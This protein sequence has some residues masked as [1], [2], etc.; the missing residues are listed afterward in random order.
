MEKYSTC[1]YLLI[2][3]LIMI[4]YFNL[5]LFN[6]SVKIKTSSK[7]NEQFNQKWI[8]VTSINEPTKQIVKLSKETQFKLLVVSDLKTNQSWY[9]SNSIFLSIADQKKLNFKSI[10]STPF[11][12]YTRKN[13]GYLFA[14]KN[15]AQFIY[16]TDDDNEPSKALIDYF[17]FEETQIQLEYDFNSPYVLNPYAH[18][19]QPTIW[20]RGF[21]LIEINKNNY[22][23]YICIQ[24]STSIVQQSVV[25]GDPDVDAIFRLTKS[26]DSQRIDIK[27]DLNSPSVRIPLYKFTPYNSQNTFFLYKAFWSLYLPHSVSF[28]LTDIWRSYWA[29]RLMWLLNSTLSFHGPNAYQLRNSHSYMDDYKQEKDMYLQAQDLI[30]FLYEWKC[31][32]KRFY[33]CVLDLSKQMALKKFWALEEFNSIQDWLD[34]LT[35]IG[36]SEPAIT[37]YDYE[38]GLKT[39]NQNYQKKFSFKVTYTP[40][41]EGLIDLKNYYGD[42]TKMNLIERSENVKYFNNFCNRKTHGFSY[43][44]NRNNLFISEGIV[45]LVVFEKELFPLINDS[46]QFLKNYYQPYFKN[47]VFCGKNIRSFNDRNR[48][49]W[50]KFDSL[51]LIDYEWPNLN[52][53][54][55]GCMKKVIDMRYINI[56]GILLTSNN[57][58]LKYWNLDTIRNKAISDTVWY[59]RSNC[60]N[61]T[62]LADMLKKLKSLNKLTIHLPYSNSNNNISEEICLPAYNLFYLPVNKFKNFN[63]LCNLFS[64]ANLFSK[65]AVPIVLSNLDNMN[66]SFYYLDLNREDYLDFKD[67]ILHQFDLSHYKKEEDRFF[68]CDN[69][70]QKIFDFYV[71]SA[72]YLEQPIHLISNAL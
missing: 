37:N 11:N 27:F 5:I 30:R 64:F 16:D 68:L 56:K 28:R 50:K 61:S 51:T 9:Q 17:D 32:F 36:Y 58:L 63:I 10:R 34:D 2:F 48:T 29:Q 47:I 8:V 54:H 72:L 6:K 41:F 55:Y 46:I 70:V 43:D 1:F 52:Q 24:K 31:K 44:L 26:L 23:D 14:I 12:S 7:N 49:K 25:N 45:L 59:S 3:F 35:S 57:I 39:Q 71:I 33:S 66:Q 15:G 22:N 20:P 65:L 53:I 18:F 21:P 13:I 19:G 4:Y 69:F 62:Y 42:E 38:Q 60:F 40:Y 67:Q